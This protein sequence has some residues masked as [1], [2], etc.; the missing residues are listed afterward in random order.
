MT[1]NRTKYTEYIIRKELA[2]ELNIPITRLD[3]ILESYYDI[4]PKVNKS[5]TYYNR[6]SVQMIR[7]ILQYDGLSKKELIKLVIK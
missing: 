1:R 4:I 6:K 2:V 5:K 3:R 7:R